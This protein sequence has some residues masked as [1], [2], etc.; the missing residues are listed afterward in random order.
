MKTITKRRLRI[1]LL[2]GG[3]SSERAI[4]LNSARSVS[5]HLHSADIEIVPVYF[6]VRKRAFAISRSQLYSNTPLDFDFKLH[7]TARPMSDAAL[8][9]LL[10]SCDIAFPAMHG[11]FG[12]DGAIQK[13]L[14]RIAVPFVG[15][16]AHACAQSFNKWKAKQGMSQAGLEVAAGLCVTK[17]TKR[18]DEILR[19]FFR[20]NGLTRAIVKPTMSGSSIGVH[21][22]LSVAEAK[23]AIRQLHA[24]GSNE[25]LV[26]PFCEGTEF[27][28]V[29]LE[30]LHD[31]VV[32]LPPIEISTDYS[33]GQ[34]FDYRRKYLPTQQAS[35]HCPPRFSPT[36]TE[37]IRN[38]ATRAFRALGLR[39][40]ARIDGWVLKGGKIVLSDV[41]PISGMEQNSFFFLA[42][43]R[44]GFSH[45]GLLRFVLARASRRNGVRFRG[46]VPPAPPRGR[47][48]VRV[49]FGGDTAERQVSVMSGTNVWLK[50][51]RSTR[52]EAEPFLLDRKN[53]VWR[54]PYTFALHHTVEEIEHVC[55]DAQRI[56]QRM[57]TLRNGIAR[58]LGLT[59]RHLTER[60]HIPRSQPL[61][62]FLRKKSFVFLGLHGG[63]GEDGTLQ[64]ML[65][66]A[67]VAHNGSG[68]A[69]TRLCM[70]KYASC[71]VITKLGIKGLTIAPKLRVGRKDYVQWLPDVEQWWRGLTEALE[72]KAIVVKPAAD[73]CSAGVSKLTS[74]S[75][76][77]SY[78]VAVKRK[79]PRIAPGTFRN[80]TNPIE[81]PVTPPNDL[82]FENFIETDLVR[83]EHS[84]LKLQRR[85]DWVEVTVGVVG[86]QGAMRALSPSLT[87][88]S[89]DTLSVEEKFQGG[90]GINIT[91]PP[92]EVAA[93]RVVE[94]VKRHI[95]SAARAL[96]LHGYARIDCFMNRKQ[97]EVMFIEANTLPALTPS[98][99]LYHQ[100]LAEARSR[101]P[102]EFIEHLIDLGVQTF[103]RTRG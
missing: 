40:V 10:R 103:G 52:Y 37:K 100:A 68:S 89:H 61:S 94:T 47:T 30:G 74:A 76:L 90:T 11:E 71:E 54:L 24:G 8:T 84:K 57:R 44:V 86:R 78:L 27:T 23:K 63:I 33:N 70:D 49:L 28:V 97:G 12:E 14:E 7:S 75:E 69:A 102:L 98:T 59:A 93:S 85:S 2:C 5:D 81:M 99:V 60:F 92:T 58:G 65:R 45:E 73:G 64:E 20:E 3:P 46:E 96:G 80:Q 88:S 25:V 39:D 19:R 26:E 35:Y 56:N 13:Y 77:E 95:E 41:N 6:D 53:R 15:S 55:G 16:S 43:T 38:D 62:A 42:G 34:I 18:I 9:K 82:L 21:S 91:P 48:A 4:S 22:V 66:R 29:V 51:R 87:V 1:A 31:E 17:R 72:T 32:A 101:F 83:V 50:L 36:I 79:L 67:G